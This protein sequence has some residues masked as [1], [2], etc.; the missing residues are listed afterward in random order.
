MTEAYPIARRKMD[1][2]C[3]PVIQPTSLKYRMR[4]S[5]IIPD[6]PQEINTDVNV[7]II[8]DDLSR[9]FYLLWGFET[10][11]HSMTA[12]G[13]ITETPEVERPWHRILAWRRTSET[14]ARSEVSIVGEPDILVV[15]RDP[16]VLFSARET[17]MAMMSRFRALQSDGRYVD[18]GDIL[19]KASFQ[20]EEFLGYTR[21]S[22]IV[23][24]RSANVSVQRPAYTP[25]TTS[26]ETK[27]S[28][29]NRMKSTLNGEKASSRS[30]S[31]IWGDIV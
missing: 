11:T 21:Y 27:A 28:L 22:L 12:D 31:E 8:E 13:V 18:L 24:I 26:T 23:E 4:E 6:E 25:S 2:S 30:S 20:P 10:I 29:W 14:G 3:L 9:G 19:V 1:L 16:L 5:Q 7:F 17:F 15:K